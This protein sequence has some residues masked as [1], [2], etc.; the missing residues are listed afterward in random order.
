MFIYVCRLIMYAIIHS[1]HQKILRITIEMNVNKAFHCCNYSYL[2]LC[3]MCGCLSLLFGGI[4][5]LSVALASSLTEKII[6]STSS[7]LSKTNH[8]IREIC[9]IFL[10]YSCAI[11]YW[12]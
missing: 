3:L 2:Q 5:G 10:N 1:I 6:T 8:I 12:Y 11:T 7:N 4:I 9:F